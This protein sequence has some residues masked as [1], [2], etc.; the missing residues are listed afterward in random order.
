[1][2]N[3]I[4]ILLIIILSI[5]VL[6]Y[7][8]KYNKKIEE[9]INRNSKYSSIINIILIIGLILLCV[10]YFKSNFAF[11]KRNINYAKKYRENNKI[12]LEYDKELEKENDYYKHCI[13]E[14]YQENF[15]NP[16]ILDGFKYVEG[17]WNTGFVIEDE[18]KNQYVWVPISNSEHK[19]VAKLIKKDFIID[20]N[21][22]KEYCLDD[23][24]EKFINSALENR[25]ILYF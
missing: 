24:Y 4:F 6:I 25:W 7:I 16:Y 17:D 11:L 10:F 8:I 1:M 9:E 20:A 23:N 5:F 2:V 14:K 12:F 18:N 15:N 19:D 21:I 13:S 22:Q 3:S